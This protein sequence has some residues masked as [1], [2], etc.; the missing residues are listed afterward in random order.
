MASKRET[1]LFSSVPP[2]T[3]AE[4][5][6]RVIGSSAGE[7]GANPSSYFQTALSLD[8]SNDWI[9]VRLL[10]NLGAAAGEVAR[11]PLHFITARG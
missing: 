3:L 2:S 6:V 4:R 9:A 8:N 5:L 11:H 7:V 10:R 1:V